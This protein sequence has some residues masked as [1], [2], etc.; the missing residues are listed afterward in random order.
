MAGTPGRTRVRIQCRGSVQGVGF[1]P[2]VHR[3]A[4]ALELSGWVFNGPDGV[5]IE[6]EGPE[7][8][9]SEFVHRLPSSLSP[10]ARLDGM[11]TTPIPVAGDT[12]FIVRPSEVGPRKRAI[13]PPD[14]ALCADCRAEMEDPED[15]RHRYPFITCTN[16]GPRFS[17]VRSLPYDRERTAMACFPLCEKCEEE[18]G[19]PVDRRFHAEPVCCPA[20]G[21]DLW[22]VDGEREL[23]RGPSAL[24]QARDA[25]SQGAIVAVKGL[26]GF[27]LACRADSD[28]AVARLR[29]RK[30]RPGKPFAVMA[31][32]VAEAR[33]L[34]LLRP[35]DEAL[36]LSHRCPVLLA[37][38][39]GSSTLSDAVAPGIGDVGVL[40]P[41]TP[42][43]VELFR[44]GNFGPL[45]MTSGNLS[46]EP[47]CRTNREAL[48]RLVGIADLFLLHN[49]DVLRR[50]DDSVVRTAPVGH[51]LM[52]RARG[53]VPEPVP[54]GL[55]ASSPVLALGGH[56]Q[57]AAC[58][59]SGEDAF[60]SQHVG[61]L[62]TDAARA[63]LREVTEG[64]EDFL[65]VT[66]CVVAVDAHPDYPSTW[67]GEELAAERGARLVRFQ[68]HLAHA[69]AVL[70][71]HGRFP[72]AGRKAAGLVLDGTGWGTDGTAWGGEWL[73]LD[74]DCRWRRLAH[75]EAVPLVGGE[76]AVREPW[77]VCVAALEAEGL[78]HL[79]PR[80][81][82][83]DLVPA[84]RLDALARVSSNRWPM[85]T[86][87][88]R[89]FE[90]AGALFGLAA[91]NDWEGEAAVRLE[92]LASSASGA[93]PWDEVGII[94]DGDA[95][96]IPFAGLLGAAAIRL[97]AG[98]GRGETALG[99][100][101]TFCRLAVEAGVR[102]LPPSVR[103][104]ALGGGCMVNRILIR[105][106]SD[107]VE[108][109]G[110]EAILA[111]AVPPGDGGLAY[112]QAVLAAALPARGTDDW[113]E[114][115]S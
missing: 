113:T 74:G 4:T 13:V 5:V 96:T 12:G 73:L 98:E 109:A 103:S 40:L 14:S 11:D 18:Y 1:R 66:A 63:F 24:G 110:F 101:T 104:V 25:L 38:K 76:A 62:D 67:Y 68:H 83:A 10:L 50:V 28:E 91:V 70:A 105:E 97:E 34:A 49:R 16:C 44:D 71:E 102:S 64:M 29:H 79:L 2:S 33:S 35:E 106:L 60:L 58:V 89:L 59:A 6:I 19:D 20:C 52:R 41:T 26:G 9:V 57:V 84:G 22:L 94:A 32:D 43:H 7:C 99:F 42:L 56:L 115:R 37:P 111:R 45:V 85:A 95:C 23:G 72:E 61:D 86:G 55:S 48:D 107:R 87:A 17:L 81:P 65:Q 114:V 108:E 46:E 77:R 3:L 93:R 112:G 53:F 15:R 80:L 21:P 47:I 88:G 82:L 31:R 90:A 69:A 36:M 78:R 30:K 27:Q 51:T 39:R 8:A 92:S 75:L 54:L 100:H